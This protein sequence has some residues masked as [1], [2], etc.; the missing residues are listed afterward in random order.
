MLVVVLT[1]PI[2][3]AGKSFTCYLFNTLMCKL[4]VIS[5]IHLYM[6][7]IDK[8]YILYIWAS[9]VAQ[10]VRYLPAM[11]ETLVRSIIRADLLEE[12]IATLSNML[13]W[14]IPRTEEPGG[15]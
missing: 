8:V 2:Q 11:Q 14:E 5:V 4:Y 6:L 7:S 10:T 9:L 1:S 15:L 12:V 3:E 13:A